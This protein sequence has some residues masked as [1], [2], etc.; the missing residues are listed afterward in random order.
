MCKYEKVMANLTQVLVIVFANKPFK[1]IEQMKKLMRK[2]KKT[3]V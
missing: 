1:Q 2:L 3:Q